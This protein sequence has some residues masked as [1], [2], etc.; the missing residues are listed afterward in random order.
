MKCLGSER[1]NTTFPSFGI[2]FECLRNFSQKIEVMTSII[3]GIE[4][5]SKNESTLKIF[6]NVEKVVFNIPIISY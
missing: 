3:G 2:H 5:L 6:V 4:R 1:W